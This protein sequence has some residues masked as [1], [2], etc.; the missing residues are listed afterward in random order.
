MSHF[1]L[2]DRV[3]IEAGLYRQDSLAAIARELKV[4]T[5]AVSEEIRRNRTLLP[6]PRCNG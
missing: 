6:A 2:A 5:R 1:G 4:Q 3:A